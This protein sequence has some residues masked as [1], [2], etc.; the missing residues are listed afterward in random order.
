[1]TCHCGDGQFAV[2]EIVGIWSAVKWGNQDVPNRAK[3][4][5]SSFLTVLAAEAWGVLPFT[6]T[7]N[8]KQLNRAQVHQF[9]KKLMKVSFK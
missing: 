5:A 6:C 4:N 1:M 3:R 9:P 2:M 8:E 7:P